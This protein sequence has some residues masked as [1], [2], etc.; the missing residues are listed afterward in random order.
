MTQPAGRGATSIS[1]FVTA[2]VSFQAQEIL[3]DKL[4]GDVKEY[5]ASAPGQLDWQKMDLSDVGSRLVV[6]NQQQ[7]VGRLVARWDLDLDPPAGHLDR[8]TTVNTPLQKAGAYL[9]SARST[10]ATQVTSWPGS[11]TRSSSRK[12]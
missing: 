6:L 2:G 7:Y 10:G 4:L 5:I 12:R 3:F 9:L 8:R 1:A 11:T